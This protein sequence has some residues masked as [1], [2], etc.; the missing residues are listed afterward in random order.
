MSISFQQ[1]NGRNVFRVDADVADLPVT[2]VTWFAAARYCNWLHNGKPRG[3]VGDDTTE[4]GAYRFAGPR[5][6]SERAT[7]ARFALPG[8]DEWFK[9]AYYRV[10][11]GYRL[12]EKTNQGE[13]RVVDYSHDAISPYGITGMYDRLW[14]WNEDPVNGLFRSV[15]SGAWFVGNNKQAAGRLY[16]TP[17]LQ[18]PNVG[19][20]VVRLRP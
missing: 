1:H 12:F 20:R 9:A 2:H 18:L 13:L 4:A 11:R 14:E 8:D 15:R 17:D 5:Q 10:G 3:P 16:A 19:F 7:T 6:V